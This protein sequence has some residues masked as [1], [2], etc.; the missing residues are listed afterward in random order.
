MKS[1]LDESV[2]YPRISAGATEKL[3]G[4]EKPHAKTVSWSYD[5]EG[6]VRELVERYCELA[7]KKSGAA[8]QSF[9]SLL[10]DQVCS[11][12]VIKCLYM[13][14]IGHSM[15]CQ[16]TCKSSFQMA[17]ACDRRSARLLPYIY[18]TNDIRQYCHVGS[19]AQHCRLGLF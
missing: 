9:K 15:V 12:M 3:P 11:Q 16:Q 17:Q 7:N 19:T 13:A 8:L 10:G 2:F 6:H 18:H 5:M 14:R 1:I 4:L